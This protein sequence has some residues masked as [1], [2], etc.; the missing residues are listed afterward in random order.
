M[1]STSSANNKRCHPELVSGSSK[2]IKQSEV[3]RFQTKFGMTVC[4]KICKKLLIDYLGSFKTVPTSITLG[5]V[6]LFSFA[7]LS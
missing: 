2:L 4:I 7:I 5:S 6:M 1:T 3:V